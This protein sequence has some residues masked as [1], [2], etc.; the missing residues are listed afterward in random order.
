MIF[1][2]TGGLETR[3]S[4]DVDVYLAKTEN[5]RLVGSHSQVKQHLQTP[6]VVSPQSIVPPVVH[7]LDCGIKLATFAPS[8]TPSCSLAVQVMTRNEWKRREKVRQVV[9]GRAR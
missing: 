5:A 3:V 9:E 8:H 7:I 6:F 1:I 2:A 4:I